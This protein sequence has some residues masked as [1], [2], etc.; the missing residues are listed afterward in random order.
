VFL[1]ASELKRRLVKAKKAN[2][3][4]EDDR[5]TLPN[6]C[7][8]EDAGTDRARNSLGSRSPDL[9][10]EMSICLTNNEANPDSF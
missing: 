6:Y 1:E 4:G 8:M 9:N 2:Q 3:E 7:I 10:G 5:N